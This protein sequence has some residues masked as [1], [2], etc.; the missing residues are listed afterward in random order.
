[1][2]SIFRFYKMATLFVFIFLIINHTAFSQYAS[3]LEADGGVDTHVYKTDTVIFDATVIED[4]SGSVDGGTFSTGLSMMH[5][6]YI[7][8][9]HIPIKYGLSDHFQISFSLPFLTKTLVYND[10]HYIK[11]GYGDTMLGF[12]AYFEPLDILSGSTTAR[13]TLPTGNVNAQ[14]YGYYVPMGYGGYTASLQQAIS[15]GN[16]SAGPLSVRLFISGIAI[17]YFESSLQ[18]DASEKDTFDSTYSWAAMGGVEVSITKNLD[19]L[20]KG[21]YISFKERRYK[22]S[23]AP[24]VWVDADDEVSQI[25]FLPFIKYRFLDDI[26]GQFGII[27]PIKSTQDKDI[28]TTYDAK[29]KMVFGIEKRFGSDSSSESNSNVIIKKPEEKAEPVKKTESGSFFFNC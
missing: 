14:D 16:F 6:P 24:T 3:P 17:Y 25:N 8:I 20:V 29:W 26:S 19:I 21:N 15:S 4:G 23:A 18:I 12:T 7:S 10:T 1:M 9:F 28:A 27:Y 22:S 5:S 13:I 2:F 11:S